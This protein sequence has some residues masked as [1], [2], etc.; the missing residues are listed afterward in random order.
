MS[1]EPPVSNPASKPT[2]TPLPPST[3]PAKQ[4]TARKE[5]KPVASDGRP[6]TTAK[7]PWHKYP[8][9]T[10][11]LC[12]IKDRL[13]ERGRDGKRVRGMGKLKEQTR[14]ELLEWW[15][16][17]TKE[18]RN[19]GDM[20]ELIHNFYKN[21]LQ[22]ND[23]EKYDGSA[24]VDSTTQAP[25]T[26]T[27]P[28]RRDSNSKTAMLDGVLAPLLQ[29]FRGRA[30]GPS[31]IWAEAHPEEVEK[32]KQTLPRLPGA[33]K[34]AIGIGFDELSVD[35][36]AHWQDKA[37]EEKA[38]I[39]N[40]P[41]ACFNN[42]TEFP[43]VLAA[44]LDC[45]IGHGPKQIGSALIDYQLAIRLKDGRVKLHQCTVGLEE[46]DEPFAEF[47]GGP[48]QEE[49]HRWR[50]FVDLKLAHNP[51]PRDERFTYGDD[52]MPKLPPYDRT[53]STEVAAEVLQA[54]FELAWDHAR[55]HCEHALPQALDWELVMKDEAAFIPLA[56][57][58]HGIRDPNEI[59]FFN[60]AVIYHR[61]YEAQD[62]TAPFRWQ[63]SKVP[64]RDLPVPHSAIPV[65]PRRNT[66]VV[67]SSPTKAGTPCRPL[68]QCSPIRSL[69]FECASSMNGG[70]MDG[71]D[72]DVPVSA[73]P[74]PA[75]N[76]STTL[77]TSSTPVTTETEASLGIETCTATDVTAASSPHVD[78]PN[79]A[80]YASAPL[81]APLDVPTN[82]SDDSDR[83]TTETEAS[84]DVVTCMATSANAAS[85]ADLDRP[86]SDD[87]VSAPL[88]A[89][90]DGL[91]T[92]FDA[93][94][95]TATETDATLEVTSATNMATAAS[96]ADLDG[97]TYISAPLPAPPV[98]TP[99]PS[100]STPTTTETKASLEVSTGIATAG[101]TTPTTTTTAT[102]ASSAPADQDGPESDDPIS[103]PLPV[104]PATATKKRG[105]T[106]DPVE[107]E[108]RPAKRRR[109]AGSEL[110][111]QAEPTRCSSR[112]RTG[113]A[114]SVSYRVLDGGKDIQ[115]STGAKAKKGGKGTGKKGAGGKQ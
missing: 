32:V 97:P 65:T 36:K 100:P 74:L 79:F 76:I 102:A 40:D 13:L 69:P 8:D 58:N 99:A 26:A 12:S 46:G 106:P 6:D 92:V 81:P 17:H 11:H 94:T 90:L 21:R 4:K 75:L 39:E 110:P 1:S 51:M 43:N 112:V 62:S 30:R 113:A 27:Q 60:M 95:P 33:H 73:N 103:T 67:F 87:H 104:S 34:R 18:G 28:T 64:A 53:W 66:R 107:E 38:A 57:R 83:T 93:S 63:S 82:L 47:Q 88:P 23:W 61:L 9:A 115:A 25:T 86:T 108:G 44:F 52:G 84:L 3:L 29:A 77:S 19:K 37:D 35:K 101:M 41:D 15:D 22:L 72:S 68:P 2:S 31:T 80:D 45:L 55:E 96:S 59:E 7:F 71:S 54:W 10:Q 42:Q 5:K 98:P 114:A 91:T 70:P 111:V 24:T 16:D 105:A 14:D 89:P 109:S 50:D 20:H 48:S 56:W 85:S 49:N 78:G